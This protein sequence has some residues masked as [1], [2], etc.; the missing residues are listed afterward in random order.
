MN[1][2]LTRQGAGRYKLTKQSLEKIPVPL[3]P[4]SEQQSIVRILKACDNVI[5]ATKN[6][7]LKKDSERN[8]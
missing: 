4:Y 3:P 7:L 5:E 2:Y 8:G 6:S 1:P